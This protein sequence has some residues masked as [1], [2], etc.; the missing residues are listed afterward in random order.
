MLALPEPRPGGSIEALRPMLNLADRNDFVLVVAWLLASLRPVG[1][2]PLLAVSGEQGSAKTVL[3]KLLR[4]LIDPNIASVR[5][6]AREQRELSIAA[7]NGHLLAFDNLS[8][9]PAWLS[10][11]LCRLASGGSFALR[12]L[13]TDDEEVLFEAARPI[14]LNGIEDV[15]CRADLADRAI[16]LTLAP[17]AE[18]QRRSEAEL[19]REFELARPAI[20]GAL[21]DALAEGLRE[22]P[23]VRLERLPRM[24]DFALWATACET[25]LWPAGCFARAYEANRKAAVVDAF[26]A[27]PVAACVREIMAE[28]STWTGSAADL[29]RAGADLAADGALNGC[30]GWPQNPRALAGRC[31]SQLLEVFTTILVA[32]GAPNAWRVAVHNAVFQRLPIDLQDFPDRVVNRPCAKADL[33]CT[34]GARRHVDRVQRGP[35]RRERASSNRAAP[36]GALSRRDRQGR[37]QSCNGLGMGQTTTI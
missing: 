18:E 33:M 19:W 31:R 8:V 2:Y 9:L 37:Q 22:L 34:R 6:L 23:R 30:R 7:N 4:A 20:L 14:L 25:A 16:F 26:E 10:D 1:P 32:L 5:A 3:S 28:R 35:S 36:V 12:R 15:I 13:Y 21:L 29:L 27:D 17:I 11:A 24:A